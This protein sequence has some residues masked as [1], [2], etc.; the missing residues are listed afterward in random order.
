[1][2]TFDPVTGLPSSG[3]PVNVNATAQELPN[4]YIYRYSVDTEY[5]IGRG[6]VA[7]VGYQGSQG[8]NLARPVPY[9]LFVPPN[10]RLGN[11]NMLLTDV[12]SQYNALARRA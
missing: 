1:M 9:Q 4:P 12:D 5:E 3:P 10:P 8:N 6:W 11:V 7:S 2:L